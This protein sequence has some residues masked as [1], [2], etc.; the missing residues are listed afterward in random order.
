MI[1]LLTGPIHYGKTGLLKK[2]YSEIKQSGVKFGGFLSESVWEKNR[3][4]GYDL[5]DLKAGQSVPF[6]R[7]E[8]EKS[9][10]KSGPF[11]F[12]PET[13]ALAKKII[14]RGR[15]SEFCIVDEVG[16][17]ELEGRGLWPALE[18]VLFQAFPPFLLV[19]RDSIL[20]KFLKTKLRGED[21][22]I[23]DVKDKDIYARMTNPELFIKDV[24]MNDT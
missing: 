6:I 24:D 18:Q 8:G 22:K 23:F 10:E 11:F 17:L 13:L 7:R 15:D 20:D 1:Y 12:I 21:I 14:L 2:L 3:V 4:A 5:F 9:W 16:P 19:V